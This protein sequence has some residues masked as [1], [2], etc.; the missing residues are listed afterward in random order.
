MMNLPVRRLEAVVEGVDVVAVQEG[1][2]VVVYQ[3][4]QAVR[5]QLLLQ[6]QQEYLGHNLK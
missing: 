6:Q 2:V 1:V 5:I 3:Q 4:R